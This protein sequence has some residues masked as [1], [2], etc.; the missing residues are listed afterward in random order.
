M[1]GI[2]AKALLGGAL[3]VVAMVFACSSAPTQPPI[4]TTGAGAPSP[5]G[6]SSPPAASS[7]SGGTSDD[8]G[9]SGGVSTS[10]DASIEGGSCSS[11]NCAT[12]CC[13]FLTNTCESGQSNTLC[14]VS[15][16]ACFACQTGTT[17][18]GGGCQ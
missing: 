11:G 8:G 6:N 15:G 14:G 9:D 4:E 10:V 13:N 5:G 12:G 2:H 3:S 18:T 1:N 16:E 7:S 17:C